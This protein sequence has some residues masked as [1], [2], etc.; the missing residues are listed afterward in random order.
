MIG[1]GLIMLSILEGTQ[2]KLTQFFRVYGRVP[3]FYYILHFYLLH[4]LVVIFFFAQGY[5]TDK[6][7]TPN[8]P[9]L[10]RPPDFGF[11]LWGVYLVWLFVFLSLYPLCK[12]YDKYKTAHSKEKK[13]L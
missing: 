9:F 1:G 6:I 2:N 10:F 7:V 8:V 5:S 4:L 11:P 12:W 13:W 3:L